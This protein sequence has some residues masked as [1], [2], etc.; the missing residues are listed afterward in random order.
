MLK[1][2]P[3]IEP[4]VPT[5]AKYPP[6]DGPLWVHEL[7]YDG[8]RIQIHKDGDHVALY[9]R[10]GIDFTRRYHVIADAARKFRAK[11]F[12]LDG[13]LVANRADGRPDFGNL[14]RNNTT[15]LAVWVFDALSH[16]NEDTRPFP[17][18]HRR[19]IMERIMGNA[20]KLFYKTFQ[21]PGAYALMAGCVELDLEGIVSKRVD[22]PYVSGR[23]TDW[24]KVK[25]ANW[26]ENNNWRNEFFNRNK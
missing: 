25:T 24:I 6:Q 23:T 10:N 20:P 13:E 1:R 11:S 21:W 2:N 18:V 19:E 3:F 9:S 26:K 16:K 14:L 22:R 15:N 4:S 12:I 7:K 8:Y 5:P 17:F